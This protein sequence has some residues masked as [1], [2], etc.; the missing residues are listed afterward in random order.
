MTVLQAINNIRASR[1]LVG[2]AR[3]EVGPVCYVEKEEE[4]RQQDGR[5]GFQSSLPHLAPCRADGLLGLLWESGV[6][7]L[8]EKIEFW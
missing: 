7:V 5:V 8:I 4:N 3:Q 2:A 1:S 6:W